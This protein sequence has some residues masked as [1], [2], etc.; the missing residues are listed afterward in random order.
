MQ[1]SSSKTREVDR[2]SKNWGPE[3][4]EI[5]RPA[6][7]QVRKTGRSIHDHAGYSPCPPVACLRALQSIRPREPC[8]ASIPLQPVQFRLAAP[9]AYLILLFMASLVVQYCRFGSQMMPPTA[10]QERVTTTHASGCRR[11]EWT[12]LVPYPRIATIFE[13]FGCCHTVP[14]NQLLAL[15]KTSSYVNFPVGRKRTTRQHVISKTR[16][17][18]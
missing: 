11:T 9:S 8:N 3:S 5:V 16:D 15:W 13:S 14:P 2:G 7:G 4:R 6:E 17:K 12:N 10:G 18:K 1:I